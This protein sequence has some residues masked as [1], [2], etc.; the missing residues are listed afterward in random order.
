MAVL[1]GHWLAVHIS[2]RLEQEYSGWCS[3]LSSTA[4]DEQSDED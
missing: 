2:L 4:A 3:N 1:H